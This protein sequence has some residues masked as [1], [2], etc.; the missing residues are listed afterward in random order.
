MDAVALKC[1]IF[2]LA[3]IIQC[4]RVSTQESRLR[5]VSFIKDHVGREPHEDVS[6]ISA[7]ASIGPGINVT[8]NIGK[9]RVVIYRSIGI[10]AVVSANLEAVDDQVLDVVGLVRSGI[11]S[12]TA[13]ASVLG[14]APH[15]IASPVSLDPDNIGVKAA[16]GDVTII[17]AIARIRTNVH[18]IAI[19]TEA[20][21]VVCH[22]VCIYC[23]VL[24]DLET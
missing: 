17:I 6:V 20:S 14:Y 10:D 8:G 18:V 15:A 4:H 5:H 21:I 3:T 22:A 2:K 13:I 19:V 1:N 12:H 23:G 24:S 16:A 7:I 9:C 11:I